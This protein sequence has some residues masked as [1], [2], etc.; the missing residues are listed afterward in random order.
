MEREQLLTKI[1]DAANMWHKTKD[2]KYKDLWY[3]LIKEFN[4]GSNYINGR[5]VSSSGGNETDD[6]WYRVI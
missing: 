6:G 1:D 4:H 3:K 2:Q 5:D